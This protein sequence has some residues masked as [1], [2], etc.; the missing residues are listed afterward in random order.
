MYTLSGVPDHFV[1]PAKGATFVLEIMKSGDG[2]VKSESINVKL[3]DAHFKS[4]KS[5]DIKNFLEQ[6]QNVS[7]VVVLYLLQCRVFERVPFQ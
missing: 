7:V 5:F 1:K 2:Y 4:G 3:T 6:T